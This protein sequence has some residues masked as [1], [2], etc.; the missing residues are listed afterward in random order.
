MVVRLHYPAQNLK[1]YYVL[2]LFHRRHLQ[3][4]RE[5]DQLD[6]WSHTLE[7]KYRKYTFNSDRTCISYTDSAR[8]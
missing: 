6:Q 8:R 2:K 5:D 3:T 7:S 1:G 4:L